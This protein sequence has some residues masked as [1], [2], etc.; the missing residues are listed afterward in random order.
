MKKYAVVTGAC[1]GIGYATV[2][3]LIRDGYQVLATSARPAEKAAALFC[4]Y[5]DAVTYLS[6]NIGTSSE[7]QTI[8][9]QAQPLPD[10]D[11]LRH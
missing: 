6:A 4:E 9:A 3:R 11:V 2:Q 5:G 8:I 7:R 10:T 1:G